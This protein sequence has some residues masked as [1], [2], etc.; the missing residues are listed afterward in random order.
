M[1]IEI[2]PTDVARA[3]TFIASLLT[4]NVPEGQ[5]GKG[6]ALRDLTVKAFAFIF[7]HL[8]KETAQVKALQSLLNVQSIAVS[9][10]P[11]I[12]RNVTVATDAILS[13][14]FITRK[15]GGFSRG[16]VTV[17]VSKKQDYLIKR[18]QRFQYNNALLFY[19]DT[20]GTTT[21]VLIP[22]RDLSTLVTTNGTV[23]GYQFNLRVIAAKTG[24]VY[25]VEA[26]DWIDSGNFSPFVIRLFSSEKFSGGEN[27]ETTDTLISRSNTAI[28]VRNLI[29]NRSI[30]A[31]LRDR[32]TDIKRLV[33]I[34]MGDPE[35]RR[36]ILQDSAV[37]NFLHLGGHYDVYVEMPI[38][39]K[40]FE[41][42]LGG[43][44]VR[45]DGRA[46]VF[47]DTTILDWT[48]TDVRVADVI[49]VTDGLPEAPQ[50]YVIREILPGELRISETNAFLEATDTAG[51]FVDYFIYRPLFGADFQV[52]PPVG[53][54]SGSAQT[55][56]TVINPNRALLPGGPHYDILDVMILDPDSGDININDVDGFVHFSARVNTTPTPIT[57][58]TEFPEYQITSAF[59]N[60]G[61]SQINFEEIIIDSAYNGKTVRVLYETLAGFSTVHSFSRD[62]FERV[63]AGNIL[64]RGFHPAYL[65]FK[66]RYS[67]KPIAT[68]SIDEAALAVALRDY[69]N[70]FP[71]EDVID[72]SDLVAVVKN[73]DANIG[74]V[75]PLTIFYNLILPDGRILGYTTLDTV[76]IDPIKLDPEFVGVLNNPLELSISDR[77]VRYLTT[78]AR[79]TIEQA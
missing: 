39:Q 24:S 60:N 66:I 47:R 37:T 40:T 26:A 6:T 31:T 9:T 16:I 56:A 22:S 51:T 73:F 18:N 62:R 19:P 43:A 41:G 70:S 50:D 5:Y 74:T 14:W 75:Y 72:T 2:S 32:F 42:Q 23:E 58:S 69:I 65:S 34:G 76:S 15:P 67:L 10:D 53:V 17:V 77:T 68:A 59:P 61:Q 12:D 44:Y 49:R 1:A 21:D 78:L 55:S 33:T 13:N 79:I 63:L 11:N 48:A 3:E 46:T 38:T 7:A 64:V 20:E 71:T 52:L 57:A 28:A 36:D 29:N 45:P 27:K 54:S 25:D 8:Q 30:D 4:D 35:M